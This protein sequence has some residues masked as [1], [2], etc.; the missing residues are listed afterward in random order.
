MKKYVW[1]VDRKL[2]ETFV[3]KEQKT[4]QKFMTNMDGSLAY[5]KQSLVFEIY[6]KSLIEAMSTTLK[7]RKHFDVTEEISAT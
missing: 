6:R 7:C 5:T 3:N 4:R 2:D 1:Y